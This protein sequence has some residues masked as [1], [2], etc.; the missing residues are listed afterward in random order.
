M[1]EEDNFGDMPD[2]C[3]LLKLEET[4]MKNIRYSA[5][6]D[7]KNYIKS[8][9]IDTS[10]D[11]VMHE[12]DRTVY[13]P[14]TSKSIINIHYNGTRDGNPELP[15]HPEMFYGFTGQDPRGTSDNPRF[16][17][18]R[19]QISKRAGDFTVRMGN[20]DDYTLAERPWT[21]QS[22][23]NARKEI[24]VRTKDNLKVFE[25]E[26]DGRIS[27]GN[28]FVANLDNNGNVRKTLMDSSFEGF[29]QQ[30]YNYRNNDNG[31]AV[32]Q[33]AGGDFGSLNGDMIN[34]ARGRV[35]NA[36]KTPWDQ[37]SGE[38][39]L[40]VQDYSQ[41]RSAAVPVRFESRGKTK[42]E[43]DW[44]V[45]TVNAAANRNIL[46]ATMALAARTVKNNRSS[47]QEQ[48][49]G[50]SIE[51]TSVKQSKAADYDV[52]A[53]VYKTAGD[54]DWS[55]PI[56]DK[57]SSRNGGNKFAPDLGKAMH[58]T[59]AHVTDNAYI[60]NV[61][62]IVSGLRSNLPE[63]R[64]RISML[65]ESDSKRDYNEYEGQSIGSGLVKKNRQNMTNASNM[66]LPA[67]STG[68]MA[69]YNYS[70]T[71]PKDPRKALHAH[72]GNTATFGGSVVRSNVISKQPQY[73]GT[74][75]VSNYI[76]GDRRYTEHVVTSN[77][78]VGRVRKTSNVHKSDTQE[79]IN[80]GGF[81]D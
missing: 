21:N 67:S 8:E 57:Y 34:S 53:A 27:G 32:S 65:V 4:N 23:S 71:T 78:T 19:D 70:N 63:D 81:G 50:V 15:R 29:D 33:F 20:N 79:G 45:S 48:D 61:G 47:N 60:T 59:S 68:E 42:Q 76:Q 38:M 22:I 56:D 41:A 17:L 12:S 7:V 2:D 30:V 31:P 64:N 9:M 52:I 35:M 44:A 3:L 55:K 66:E 1:S 13:N 37:V 5:E 14:A 26:R 28:N 75:H 80:D 58:R 36:K 16:D 74:T 62:N 72:H 11:N 51:N 49:H 43:Q 46:A 73:R 24:M 54:I 25:M 69:I 77:P 6:T 10:P 40:G 18:M 39:D